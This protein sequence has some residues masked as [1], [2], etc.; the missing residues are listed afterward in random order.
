MTRLEEVCERYTERFA[1][2]Y[3]RIAWIALC[4]SFFWSPFAAV[5]SC[6]GLS[7]FVLAQSVRPFQNT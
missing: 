3:L 2:A 1:R 6:F 7:A 5:A 4:L